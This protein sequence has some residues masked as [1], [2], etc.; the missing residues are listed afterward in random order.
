MGLHADLGGG[1]R[2][3]G[4]RGSPHRYW[5]N[6][7][8]HTESNSSSGMTLCPTCDAALLAMLNVNE[9]ISQQVK[10]SNYF[11]IKSSPF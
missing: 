10:I 1:R 2:T 6:V 8:L 11:F 5:E 7:R 9:N 4:S 3:R